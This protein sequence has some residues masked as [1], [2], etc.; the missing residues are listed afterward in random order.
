MASEMAAVMRVRVVRVVKMSL[1]DILDSL[2][3]WTADKEDF[4]VESRDDGAKIAVGLVENA[5]L[6]TTSVER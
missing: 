1:L 4:R 5:A 2:S 6:V 3:L